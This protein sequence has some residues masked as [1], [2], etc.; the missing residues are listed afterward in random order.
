[1]LS[2]CIFLKG[3]EGF[4]QGWATHLQDPTILLGM[5]ALFG[6]A[7]G[8]WAAQKL[9][10]LKTILDLCSAN[11]MSWQG[12][13]LNANIASHDVFLICILTAK[14]KWYFSL[15]VH[16]FQLSVNAGHLGES[17]QISLHFFFPSYCILLPIT[18]DISVG[19]VLVVM[20]PWRICMP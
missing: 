14:N 6:G 9:P 10:V 5:D 18:S 11:W 4:L 17:K 7:A 2:A 8:W 1:M 13:K 16:S 19:K 15:S 12:L 3:I 20:M